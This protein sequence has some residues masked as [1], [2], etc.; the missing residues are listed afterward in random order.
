MAFCF[1]CGAQIDASV[2]F[3][4]NC[5]EKNAA[6][7]AGQQPAPQPVQYQQPAPQPVQYQQPAQY[8]M[9][10]GQP[11][12]QY[13]GVAVAAPKKKKKVFITIIIVASVLLIAGAIV[14]II[15]L[16]G[17]S[18]GGKPYTGAWAETGNGYSLNEPVL[19]ITNDGRLVLDSDLGYYKEYADRI[20]T[21]YYDQNCTRPMGSLQ[22][23]IN[24]DT[25]T[26]V[27][28]ECDDNGT[29]FT[30][31]GRSEVYTKVKTYSGTAISGVWYAEYGGMLYMTDDELYENGDGVDYRISGDKIILIERGDEI[32]FN[33]SIAGDTLTIYSGMD[34]M[35]FTR[36][37]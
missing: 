4:E 21:V 28:G 36:L 10:Y 19:V 16:G 34:I 11:M 13:G 2:P 37:I 8:P 30:P 6:Y 33:Y 32:E 7:A 9:Q 26:I 12:P 14:L 22:Y 23:I 25:L 24:A 18:V 35:K 1:N 15:L 5:G 3:C 20:I 17:G 31:N 27:L 29:N